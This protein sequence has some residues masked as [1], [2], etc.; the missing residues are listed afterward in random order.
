MDAQTR[1]SVAPAPALEV[2]TTSEET[3]VA[4][5]RAYRDRLL[6][7]AYGITRDFHFACDVVQETFL[8]AARE[9]RLAAPDFH[10]RAWLLRVCGN[11]A[12]NRLR[13]EGRRRE[14]DGAPGLPPDDGGIRGLLL[15]G[16]RQTTDPAE[17]V[18]RRQMGE[19]LLKAMA[20]LPATYRRAL[21]LRYG[22]GMTCADIASLLEVPAGTVMSWIHRARQVLRRRLDH[23]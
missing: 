21:M 18:I 4:L 5:Y 3:I 12:L 16:G 10:V 17:E 14:R 20:E 11:L 7:H 15:D 19:E 22:E 8:R 6:G 23:E 9:P 1:E 13:D 2:S